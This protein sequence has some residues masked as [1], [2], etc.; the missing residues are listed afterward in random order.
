MG[1]VCHQWLVI[2]R[3]TTDGSCCLYWCRFVEYLTNFKPYF[4][5]KRGVLK[6]S[7]RCG[8]YCG[9]EHQV[10][11]AKNQ[12]V[13]ISSETFVILGQKSKLCRLY[14]QTMIAWLHCTFHWTCPATHVLYVCVVSVVRV[15]LT[16]LSYWV[17]QPGGTSRCSHTRNVCSIIQ[18]SEQYLWLFLSLL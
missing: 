16:L 17:V 9:D 13:W 15:F 6:M 14:T 11:N 7:P 12:P 4:H 8:E 10:L 3:S 2:L 5:P 1:R 18:K